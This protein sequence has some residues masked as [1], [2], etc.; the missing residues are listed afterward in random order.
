MVVKGVNEG[1]IVVCKNSLGRM[2]RYLVV[3]TRKVTKGFVGVAVVTSLRSNQN[4][5]EVEQLGDSIYAILTVLHNNLRYKDVTEVYA[6]TTSR[7]AVSIYN[8]CILVREK[9]YDNIFEYCQTKS[10]RKE[11]P[12]KFTQVY[13][14]GTVRPKKNRNLI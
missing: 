12:N 10:Y 4:I 8:K 9:Q 11:A 3:K 6:F 2:G 14:G 13:S 1:D 5:E 7:K